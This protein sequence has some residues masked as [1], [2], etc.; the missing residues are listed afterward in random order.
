MRRL[1]H[2]KGR[3]VRWLD[4]RRRQAGVSSEIP[5]AASFQQQVEPRLRPPQEE[6]VAYAVRLQQ[7]LD[8][9]QIRLAFPQFLYSHRST[10]L[11]TYAVALLDSLVCRTSAG[12]GGPLFVTSTMTWA[13]SPRACMT[14]TPFGSPC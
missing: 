9:A 1:R 8:A 3:A 11:H 7:A 4:L 12:I 10:V 5:L 14:M 13:V 6:F 2:G